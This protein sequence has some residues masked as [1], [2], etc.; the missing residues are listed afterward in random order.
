M[1]PYAAL[2]ERFIKE[3]RT[4]HLLPEEW[5]TL[6][7]INDNVS[8]LRK[9]GLPYEDLQDAIFA[10]RVAIGQYAMGPARDNFIDTTTS[11]VAANFNIEDEND[12]PTDLAEE[13]TESSRRSGKNKRKAEDTLDKLDE[14]I[15][16]IKMQCK[17]EEL[18]KQ[19]TRGKKLSDVLV[20]L[21]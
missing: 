16:V 12:V 8:T 2:A 21:Q 14:L 7:K 4:F 19:D 13:D 9:G 18:A 17:R 1:A 11:D 5:D 15:E 3:T 10:N 6:I 20:I